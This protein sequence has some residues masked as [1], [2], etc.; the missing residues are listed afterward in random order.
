MLLLPSSCLSPPSSL[1][2]FQQGELPQ[3]VASIPAIK[4]AIAAWDVSTT[5]TLVAQWQARQEETK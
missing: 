1:P 3:H 2:S 4:E 5:D